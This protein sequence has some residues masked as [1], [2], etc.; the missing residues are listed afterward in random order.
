[1]RWRQGEATYAS[2]QAVE[3]ARVLVRNFKRPDTSND[4]R[5]KAGIGDVR[6]WPRLSLRNT[7]TKPP[8][9][10]AALAVADRIDL[11]RAE[12]RRRIFV[13]P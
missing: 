11:W 5:Q 9:D 2:R 12:L 6:N 3:G 7:A 4:L 13:S 10:A 1:V 8:F